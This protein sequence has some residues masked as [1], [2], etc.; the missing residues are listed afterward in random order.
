MRLLFISDLWK[1]F[2]GGAEAYAFNV[3]REMKARGHEIGVLTSYENA[4]PGDPDFGFTLD[5]I[6]GS[7]IIHSAE[8]RA[9]IVRRELEFHQPDVIFIHRFFAE[10]RACHMGLAGRKVIEIV[11]HHHH[12]PDPR[13][14][15]FNSGFTASRPENVVSC[16]SMIMLPPAYESEVHI[17]QPGDK[18]GIV[19]LLEGKGA[20]MFYQIAAACPNKAFLAMRG[21]FQAQE[22]YR[23]APNIEFIEPVANMRDF[24]ARCRIVLMP[25]TSEDAGTIPQ[26]AALA[27]I[28]CISSKV[29]GLVETNAG[30]VFPSHPHVEC[31]VEEIRRLDNNS[32]Y[33]E[34]VDRQRFFVGQMNWKR[35]FDTIDEVVRG[36]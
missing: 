12:Y 9:A 25:S 13:F 10:D 1:P 36:L 14:V 3:A 20:D 27:G 11:H 6:L 21:F 2:P 26:E 19:K 31:W 35:A 18:I 30:G 23:P 16:P 32:L 7:H 5:K 34:V 24:Y 15:I 17:D 29:G 33:K 8:E 4:L 22:F 28:P